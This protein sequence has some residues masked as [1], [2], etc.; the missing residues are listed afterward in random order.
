M[1]KQIMILRSIDFSRD[2]SAMQKR[3]EIAQDHLASTEKARA[4]LGKSKV[5]GARRVEME[6]IR[7]D[8]SN[9]T[10]Y[11]PPVNAHRPGIAISRHS[12]TYDTLLVPPGE[13]IIDIRA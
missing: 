8:S 1:D 11:A 10:S 7:P 9:G 3:A 4:A 12:W 2:V 5:Q 6:E 13:N